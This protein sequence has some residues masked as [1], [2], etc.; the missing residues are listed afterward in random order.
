[1]VI[2]DTAVSSQRGNYIENTFTVTAVKTS[3]A[4]CAASRVFFFF[5][6]SSRTF[7]LLSRAKNYE[8]K[9]KNEVKHWSSREYRERRCDRVRARARTATIRRPDSRVRVSKATVASLNRAYGRELL[10]ATR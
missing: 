9:K 1:M 5:V 2:H 7:A 10:S 8:K 4:R 6:H 3:T